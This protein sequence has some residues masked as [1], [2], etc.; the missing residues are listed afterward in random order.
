VSALGLGFNRSRQAGF[1]QKRTLP[2]NANRCGQQ[3]IPYDASLKMKRPALL[4]LALA[5]STLLYGCTDDYSSPDRRVGMHG[6]PPPALRL[7]YERHFAVADANY[8][9]ALGE[10]HS[11]LLDAR[12]APTFRTPCFTDVVDI[13]VWANKKR[14]ADAFPCVALQATVGEGSDV[15]ETY[16][17]TRIDAV[18]FNWDQKVWQVSLTVQFYGHDPLVSRFISV[19]QP[20]LKA[21]D[22]QKTVR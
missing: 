17:R 14:S 1:G 10:I 4:G 21:M 8:L 16:I 3:K 5:F 22:L 13:H 19:T 18:K 12:L 2:F 11:F 9:K 7:V 20:Q 6:E 15:T